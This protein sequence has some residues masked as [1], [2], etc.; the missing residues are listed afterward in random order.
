MLTTIDPS[1]RGKTN[2]ALVIGHL[3]LMSGVNAD[4]ARTVPSVSIS[5]SNESSL[6][7]AVNDVKTAFGQG[8]MHAT[9][10]SNDESLDVVKQNVERMRSG[11][12][13]AAMDDHVIVWSGKVP[14]LSQKQTPVKMALM[15]AKACT[16]LPMGMGPNKTI[17]QQIPERRTGSFA[18]VY[19]V[20]GSHNSPMWSWWL[21]VVVFFISLIL[22]TSY[23]IR[24]GYRKNNEPQLNQTAFV[25]P[26]Q[27]QQQQQQTLE[28]FNP[29]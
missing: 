10:V 8:D 2:D 9:I 1:V 5:Q 11:L 20:D 22:I 18:F 17:M 7:R 29:M 4:N 24:M 27:R 14:T 19:P 6:E 28:V 21:W 26:A 3:V 25:N 13:S 12:S 15:G 23:S 16:I